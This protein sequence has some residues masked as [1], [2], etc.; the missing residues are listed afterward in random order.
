LKK[1][2]TGF[3]AAVLAVG[4]LTGCGQ[5]REENALRDLETDS[6]VTLCDYQNLS[7]SVE[8]LTVTDSERDFYVMDAYSRYATLENSGITNRAAVNG[9]TVNIDYVGKIDG[10]EFDGGA[11]SGAFLVLGSD[12]YI[13]GFEEG[14]TGVRPGETVEL[15]L[16]FP[17]K[18]GS[19]PD[20]AGKAVKFTVTVNYIVELRDA[21]VADMGLENVST[22][23]E[24][25]QYVYDRLYA[26]KEPEYNDS[27]KGAIMAELFEQCTYGELPE[28]ILEN[29]K[30]YV[31]GI[32]NS[33]AEYGL[34]ADTYTNTFFGMDADTYVNNYS[35]ELTKQDITLQ[36]IA[37]K[38]D[39][40]ISDKELKSVLEQYAKEAGANTV[41][42]YLGDNSAEE[43]RNAL[44]MEKVMDYLIEQTQVN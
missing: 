36:A 6:Y 27:V 1:K 7:V 18:Y 43:Y 11:A 30:E 31:S 16:T 38:E 35:T 20:L 40:N 42:E 33:A 44:M 5:S 13:D 41:E 9:D 24:L 3:L 34:D 22:V 17:E 4:L 28:T 23:A 26:G 32:I 39:L 19:N 29:N 8:P 37:N 25:Q 21:V 2:I 12:S 10:V 14:L 15:D